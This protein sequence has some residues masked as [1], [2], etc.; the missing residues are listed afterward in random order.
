MPFE[1]L[2]KDKLLAL[3]TLQKELITPLGLSH[4]R[5]AGTYNLD[6]D[7]CD[8]QAGFFLSQKSP[9]GPDEPIVYKSGSFE[10]A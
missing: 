8:D 1:K 10:D 6:P 3:E 7:T 2:A 5:S 4:P 9:K